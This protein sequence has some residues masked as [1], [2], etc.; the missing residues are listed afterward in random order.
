MADRLEKQN[1]ISSFTNFFI[2]IPLDKNNIENINA[3]DSLISTY[4]ESEL[5]PLGF[6]NSNSI[7]KFYDDPQDTRNAFLRYH[8]KL[9]ENGLL[10]N[11]IIP[12]ISFNRCSLYKQ[13]YSDNINERIYGIKSIFQTIYHELAHLKQHLNINDNVSSID[14]I[15]CAEDF[16]L[17]EIEKQDYINLYYN[18]CFTE[19][20]AE[21]SSLEEYQIIMGYDKDFDDL[22]TIEL[23]KEVIGQCYNNTFERVKYLICN[24]KHTE[25]L[26]YFPVLQREFNLDGTVKTPEQLINDMDTQH[27]RIFFDK[28][29]TFQEKDTL[30]FKSQKMYYELLYRSFSSLSEKEV[31]DSLKNIEPSK[32]KQL[33]KLMKNHFEFEKQDNLSKLFSAQKVLENYKGTISPANLKSEFDKV[34]PYVVNNSDKKLQLLDNI[35]SKNPDLGDGPDGR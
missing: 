3:L 9:R 31:N 1:A 30:N 21:I 14:T 32:M 20:N 34:M 13:L 5:Q 24:Q 7:I 22:K 17:Q 12:E 33:I 25:L 4:V 16:L 10:D 28:D 11:N 23:G 18:Y 35:I 29:L 15:K 27:S 26:Q 2:R 19:K 8:R 6:S